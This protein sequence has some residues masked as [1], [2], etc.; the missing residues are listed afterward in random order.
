LV[1]RGN[2]GS[3]TMVREVNC[4]VEMIIW[5]LSSNPRCR[6]LSTFS[7]FAWPC[8]RTK[9]I[10]LRISRKVERRH[11]PLIPRF[12]SNHFVRHYIKWRGQYYYSKAE[13][14]MMISNRFKVNIHGTSVSKLII[15]H[16]QGDV[17]WY[18]N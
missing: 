16:S 1:F 2:I 5:K 13:F 7:L 12:P 17:P 10:Q 18:S 11:I 3:N 14:S 15:N 8:I 6:I 9:D 4:H